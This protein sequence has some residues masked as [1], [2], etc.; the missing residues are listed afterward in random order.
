M[1][2]LV[3]SLENLLPGIATP[4]SSQFLLEQ[5]AIRVLSTSYHRQL[6]AQFTQPLLSRDYSARNFSTGAFTMV[7]RIVSGEYLD[8]TGRSYLVQVTD[9]PKE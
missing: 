6:N 2:I 3:F 1:I 4:T 7:A 5:V 9:S 8:L